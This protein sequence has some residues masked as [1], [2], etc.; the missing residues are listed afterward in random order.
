[1]H[2]GPTRGRWPV[3]P[4]TTVTGPAVPLN[5]ADVNTDIIIPQKWLITIERDGLGQGLFGNLRYLNDSDLPN[6]AFVLNEARFQHAR[7]LVAGPNYGCGSS[8]EH[9]V[10]AHLGYGISAVISSSF[11]PIFF[12]NAVKNGLALVML[13][14]TDVS[15]ILQQLLASETNTMTVDVVRQVVVGPDHASCT[16]TM[17]PQQ[18][19]NLLT[20]SDEIQRTME[21]IHAID[22]F[23]KKDR[24]LRPWV[25]TRNFA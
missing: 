3:K 17:D 22:E 7:I 14:E 9:A 6:P 8:R 5:Q 19:S 25:W 15:R 16:F 2:R 12:D 18:R 10:W 24:L 1:M 4:F 11:G 13:P 23:E 21:S 20:G